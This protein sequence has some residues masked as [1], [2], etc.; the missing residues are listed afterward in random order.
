MFSLLKNGRNLLRRVVLHTLRR[1]LLLEE[2]VLIRALLRAATG[3]LNLLNQHSPDII[4]GNLEAFR[5]FTYVYNIHLTYLLAVFHLLSQESLAI[6]D[7]S[8]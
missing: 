2:A 5:K 8:I 4:V 6:L 1:K 7:A 3:R